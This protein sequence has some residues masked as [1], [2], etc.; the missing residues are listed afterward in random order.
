MSNHEKFKVQ[1]RDLYGDENFLQKDQ[2]FDFTVLDF[3]RWSASD[4]LNNAQRGVLAEFIVLKALNCKDT[5]RTEWDAFDLITQ[6][7]NKIEVK[8]SAYLQS[9][10]QTRFS[11]ITYGIRATYAY[12]FNEMSYEEERKRQSNYYIFCLLTEKDNEKI[13]PL[14]LGQWEFYLLPTKVLDE[15]LPEGKTISLS[16]LKRLNPKVLTYDELSELDI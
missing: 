1:K 10:K 11:S 9:W 16:S 15:K 12:D 3:W 5:K 4:L 8:S 6:K 13:N 14:D 7:G 2:E